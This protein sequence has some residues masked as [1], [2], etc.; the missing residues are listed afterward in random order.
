MA[1]VELHI[2]KGET[3][4][5]KASEDDSWAGAVTVDVVQEAGPGTKTVRILDGKGEREVS[6]AL[7]ELACVGQED[8]ED[9]AELSNLNE[10]SLMEL[11]RTRYSS[12]DHASIYT[13]AG[14]V[15]V[16]VNPFT[17]VSE[18][19]SGDLREQV[20]RCP[21]HRPLP[22]LRAQTGVMGAQTVAL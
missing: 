9:I 22:S 17:D 18:L 6:K 10:P 16:A 14:P 11:V 13:R 2:K 21:P 8:A 19:Y 15:L 20:F 3:V 1:P 4:W 12:G 5:L 7:V